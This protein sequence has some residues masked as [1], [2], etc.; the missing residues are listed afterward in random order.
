MLVEKPFTTS[1]QTTRE[2]FEL[3]EKH[4]VLAMEA[5]FTRWTD[6]AV[7]L[8]ALLESETIGRLVHI[9]SNFVMANTSDGI[10]SKKFGGGVSFAI[11]CYG[12][13]AIFEAVN[14]KEKPEIKAIGR[15]MTKNENVSGDVTVSA[16]L[17]FPGSELTASMLLT[18]RGPSETKLDDLNYTSYIGTKGVI[19]F[20]KLNNPSEI[21]LITLVGEKTFNTSTDD[22]QKGYWLDNSHGLRF[23]VCFF[24]SSTV[25]FILISL[26][27]SQ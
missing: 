9:Q 20:N 6:G 26:L 7:K 11:A 18:L 8:R 25:C 13:N 5:L 12:L 22:G 27:S 21:K 4:G 1:P 3:A 2:L 19:Q 10:L 17:D 16:L 15:S 14:Y 24:F 23:V